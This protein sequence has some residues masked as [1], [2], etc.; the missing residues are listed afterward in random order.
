MPRRP[1]PA[2]GTPPVR[3]AGRSTPSCPVRR[4]RR[5]RGAGPV[6]REPPRCRPLLPRDSLSPRGRPAAHGAQPAQRSAGADT[7]GQLAVGSCPAS[8]SVPWPCRER[9]SE[10]RRG[11]AEVPRDK[12]ESWS[13]KGKART[14]EEFPVLVNH[15]PVIRKFMFVK[16]F[17]DEICKGRGMSK[18][19]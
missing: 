13:F 12:S 3:S 11:P 14:S 19:Y 18:C 7:S 16:H 4:G 10:R 6:L 5:G 2:R 8:S 17:A 15:P 9:A 1:L